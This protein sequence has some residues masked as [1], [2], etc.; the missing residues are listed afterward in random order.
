MKNILKKFD[1]YGHPT[2]L[3]FNQKGNTVPTV[4]GGICSLLV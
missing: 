3:N 1:I 2:G 4:I